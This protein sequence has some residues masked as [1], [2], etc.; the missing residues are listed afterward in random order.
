MKKVFPLLVE[1]SNQRRLDLDRQEEFRTKCPSG[2]INLVSHHP[3]DA[4]I[5][6]SIKFSAVARPSGNNARKPS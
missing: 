5:Q 1:G 2:L 3:Q 6:E 4:V